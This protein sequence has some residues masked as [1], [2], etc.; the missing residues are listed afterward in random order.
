MPPL[1][2]EADSAYVTP[3]SIYSIFDKIPSILD[4][5]NTPPPPQDL[6]SS[7]QL[8]RWV[9]STRDATSSLP[10]DPADQRRTCYQFK[11]ASS[12]LAQVPENPDPNT[13]E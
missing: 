4:D 8:P 6:P 11:G 5:E 2:C 10:G 9:F 1:A 3:L 12:F 13:F 7:L